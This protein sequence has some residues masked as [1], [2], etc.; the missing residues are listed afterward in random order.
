MIYLD[1]NAT[2]RPCPEAI[3]EMQDAL[4][5]LWAN[6]SSTHTAGQAARG[7]LADARTRVARFLGCQGTELVFTSGATEA[8]HMAVLGGLALGRT[9]GRTRLVLSCIEHPAMLA[10]AQRLRAE[11]TIVDLIPVQA[12]GSLDLA[13]AERLIGAD[14]ALVSVMGANNETGVCMPLAALE[15]LA[16]AVG[17]LMHVDAT[18]LAGRSEQRFDASGADL[19]SISAHKLHGPKGVGALVVR[20]GLS[21]PALLCGRQERQRRGGTENLPGILGFAAAA[22]RASLTLAAD[23]L[24]LQDLQARLERGLLALSPQVQVYGR[25]CQRLPNTSCLRFGLL[26]ADRVLARLERAGVLASSG[27]ACSAGG[28]Q[29][30][31]VLLAMGESPERAKAAIRLSTGRDTRAEDIEQVIAAVTGAL[32]PLLADE[33]LAAA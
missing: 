11:G 8:N 13:A 21:L 4:R 24:H 6:P 22:E 16:H 9:R 28:T 19:W 20:K 14:V 10:L 27:A 25:S 26:D 33:A 2:T 5:T 32:L 1:H 30:S 15:Q 3:E 18:Q 7:A 31:H 29:P 17:A 12:D 23:L